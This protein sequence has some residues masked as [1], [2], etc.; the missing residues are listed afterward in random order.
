MTFS[1][2]SG[3]RRS[4]KV[5]GHWQVEEMDLAPHAYVEDTTQYVAP[6]HTSAGKKV[7]VCSVCG[8]VKETVLPKEA[9][10]WTEGTPANNSDGFAVTPL[11]CSCGKVGAK[12]AVD[13]FTG[14]TKTNSTY[15]HNNN[16]TVTYKIVVSKAGNYELKIG[17][18]VANN[19]TKDLSAA[20][21][22]VKVGTGDNAVDVPVS[23]GTYE[24]LGIGTSS[25]KLFVL[26]PTIALAE[27]ENVISLSQ[28][29]GGYRLTFGGE[30]VVS[31]L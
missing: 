7:E 5:C 17:A 30:L 27:G 2:S 4:C 9:H 11:S 22:T 14:N 1:R 15:K 31:E 10:D 19:R 3:H 20:P 23:S 21:Y 13:S 6:T 25:A 24:A 8:D 12:M 26:C 16:T 29:G 18:F 28:G